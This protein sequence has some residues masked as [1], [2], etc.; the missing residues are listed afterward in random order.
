MNL[1]QIKKCVSRTRTCWERTSE[2]GNMLLAILFLSLTP[3][4]TPYKLC[5]EPDLPYRKTPQLKALL[6][7]SE[8]HAGLRILA[9]KHFCWIRAMFACCYLT[10]ERRIA[11]QSWSETYF[12]FFSSSEQDSQMRTCVYVWLRA[13]R[14]AEGGE[15]GLAQ[16]Y[17]GADLWK[18]C[19]PGEAWWAL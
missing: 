2:R 15:V 6:L 14:A 12:V 19:L 3:L 17:L 5:K 13:G 8:A 7:P 1:S 10:I 18:L 11:M 9:L 4:G 16:K